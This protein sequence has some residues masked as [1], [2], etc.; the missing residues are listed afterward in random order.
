MIILLIIISFIIQNFADSFRQ[1][2][3]DLMQNNIKHVSEISEDEFLATII[4][5]AETALV[6]STPAPIRGYFHA[7]VL[8]PELQLL[9]SLAIQTRSTNNIFCIHLSLF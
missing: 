5:I 7:G 8:G 6:P 3:I 2:V 9:E 1:S 4:E